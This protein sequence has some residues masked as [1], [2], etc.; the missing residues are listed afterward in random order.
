MTDGT[1]LPTTREARKQGPGPTARK[2]QDPGFKVQEMRRGAFAKMGRM[3]PMG[4]MG[5][6]DEDEEENEDEDEEDVFIWRIG[7]G[8]R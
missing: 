7:R 8:W 6:G 2:L 3:G 4:R 5:F 1:D